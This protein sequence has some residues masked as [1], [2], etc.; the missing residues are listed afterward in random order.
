M[1]RSERQHLKENPLAQ[2]AWEVREITIGHSRQ[3]TVAVAA[4][5]V[6]A[7]GT[8]GYFFWQSRRAANAD[9][10]L[11]AAVAVAETPV[12]PQPPGAAPQN[13]AT[14]SATTYPSEK[15]RLEAVLPKYL[16]VV[17]IYP[18]SRAATAALYQAANALAALGRSDEAERRYQEVI[19]RDGNGI[20]GQMARLGLADVQQAAGH[21]DRAIDTYV[22][23]STAPDTPL[24]LD[25]ILLQ[26]ARTYARAGKTDEA[27]RTYARIVEEFPQS[28]YV[29]D[30]Q[31]ALSAIKKS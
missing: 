3:A 9:V 24:P 27:A 8:S 30:A 13:P 12:V 6:L 25:G 4:V 19:A 21:L 22:A 23:L 18:S 5:V 17:D 7:V 11:A 31:E 16:S 15:A 29:A 1:K 10:L 20:Y 2:L 28:L 26:L 14:P